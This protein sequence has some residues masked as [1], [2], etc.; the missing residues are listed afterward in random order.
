MKNIILFGIVGL[1][2]AA[3]IIDAIHFL[4]PDAKY[5]TQILPERSFPVKEATEIIMVYNAYNAIYPA[6]IDYVKK[7]LFPS[8]YPCNLCY[9]AF[10]NNGPKPEWQNFLDSLTFKKTE[11]H[12]EDIRREYLPETLLLPVV[13]LKKNNEVELLV[14]AGTINKCTSLPQLIDSVRVALNQ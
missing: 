3:G 11:M 10:G 6:A 4:K 13:L 1:L 9:L 12:K 7:N 14:N 5:K 2:L 8:T